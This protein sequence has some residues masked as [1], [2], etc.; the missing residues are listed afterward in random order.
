MCGCGVTFFPPTHIAL[1]AE[2]G[3][4]TTIYAIPCD[5]NLVY[6]KSVEYSSKH[7]CLHII[8]GRLQFNSILVGEYKSVMPPAKL[9]FGGEYL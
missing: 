7:Y 6:L 1:K 5:F 4:E 2:V 3:R 8:C 9:F